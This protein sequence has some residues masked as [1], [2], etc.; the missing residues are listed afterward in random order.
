MIARHKSSSSL[1][2]VSTDGSNLRPVMQFT[3]ENRLV[4]WINW[5]PDERY[6]LFTMGRG[7]THTWDIWALR[8]THSL[9][10]T[11]TAKPIQ[12]T[13]GAM[14]F[15][16][17]M[18]SPDGKQVFAIGGQFRKKLARYDLKSGQFGPFLSSISAEQ[19]DFSKDGN[20]V[21]YVT[22]PDGIL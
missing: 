8:E 13:S 12:L 10:R 14:S 9:F 17:P 21:A 5:T 6:F 4:I 16:S 22:F 2:E 18:P 15:W 1:L 19:L 3:G 11:R 7:N 20:W